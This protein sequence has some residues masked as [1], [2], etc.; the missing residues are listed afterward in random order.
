VAF[1][2]RSLPVR[3]LSLEALVGETYADIKSVKLVTDQ[4]TLA[5]SGKIDNFNDPRFDLRADTNLNLGSL[6]QFAGVKRRLDG[7]VKVQV[8]A[9]GR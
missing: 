5:S 1:E 6:V 7:N 9:N 3:E 8:A 4:S 2:N